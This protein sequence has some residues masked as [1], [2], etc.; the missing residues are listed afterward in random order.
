MFICSNDHLTPITTLA[1]W[2]V[3]TMV[4]MRNGYIYSTQQHNCIF[5]QVTFLE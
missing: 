1:H 2:Q 3:S 4:V 5:T